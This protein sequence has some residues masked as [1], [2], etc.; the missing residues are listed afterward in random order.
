[1]QYVDC[2]F[3]YLCNSTAKVLN[4]SQIHYLELESRYDINESTDIAY[5]KYL[6]TEYNIELQYNV[7][8]RLETGLYLFATNVDDEYVDYKLMCYRTDAS[9]LYKLENYIKNTY[10]A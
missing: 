3:M 4:E 9:F 5:K 10:I 2:A 1:M 6:E 8:Y 7:E